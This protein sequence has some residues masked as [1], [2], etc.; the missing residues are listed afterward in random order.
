VIPCQAAH[1][2]LWEKSSLPTV[3]TTEAY[4]CL[5]ELT[6]LLGLM[7]IILAPGL[8]DMGAEKMHGKSRAD[9]LVSPGLSTQTQGIIIPRNHTVAHNIG[10]GLGY[11]ELR[12]DNTS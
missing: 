8:E 4:V 2:R 6:F 10:R 1:D 3:S 5:G 7:I 9:Q 12:Q 11:V